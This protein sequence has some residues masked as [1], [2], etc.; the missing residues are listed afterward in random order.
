[1]NSGVGMGWW[2]VPNKEEESGLGGRVAMRCR[3]TEREVGD[4]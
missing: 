1:M 2:E 3:D 4:S